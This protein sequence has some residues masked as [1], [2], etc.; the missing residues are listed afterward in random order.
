[1]DHFLQARSAVLFHPDDYLLDTVKNRL[2]ICT[3]R[4]RDIAWMS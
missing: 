4:F 3:E 1:M 2:N